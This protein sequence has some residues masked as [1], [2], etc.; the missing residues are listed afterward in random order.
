MAQGVVEVFLAIIAV[1]AL[2][3]NILV[4]TLFL[5]NRHW[6]KNVHTFL[7][8]NLAIQDILTAIGLLV[9]PRFVQPIDAYNPPSDSILAELFCRVF[10]S[11]YIPFALAI[12]SVYTCLMLTIDRWLAVLRPMTYRRFSTSRIAIGAMLILPWVAG[13][14]LEVSSILNVRVDKVNGTFVC[15]WFG[16]ESSPKKTAVALVTF[17]WMIVV[18][19]TLIIIAYV[20]I[21]TKLRQSSAKVRPVAGNPNS[22]QTCAQNRSKT[23]SIAH[24]KRLTRVACAASIAIIVCWL[25]DQLYYCLSQMDL[26]KFQTPLHMGLVILAFMNSMVNPF[27]YSFSNKQYREEFKAILCC[28]FRRQDARAHM[29]NAID[30][31]LEGRNIEI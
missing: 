21:V 25:P 26:A 14:S 13:L 11:A 1:F 2:I 10:W 23:E 22:A 3:G 18:P 5:K 31:N 8:M 4:V 16:E 9:L 6:L 29:E 15:S 24:L 28:K 17:I 7:L 27:L 12:A 30:R 19:A 20:M